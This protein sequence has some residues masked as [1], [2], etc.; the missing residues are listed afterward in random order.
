M[1]PLLE[2][3][4]LTVDF[5]RAGSRAESFRALGPVALRIDR[6]ESVAVVGES[7]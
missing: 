1:A 7:G 5:K 6:G 4:G 3:S 2:V